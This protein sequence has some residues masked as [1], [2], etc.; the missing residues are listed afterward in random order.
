MNGVSLKQHGLFSLT[1]IY[2]GVG[3]GGALA[4][5]GIGRHGRVALCELLA[6]YRLPTGGDALV[7]SKYSLWRSPH[8]VDC[9]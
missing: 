1:N 7:M 2:L 8:K 6:G 4:V 5:S 9:F 3:R